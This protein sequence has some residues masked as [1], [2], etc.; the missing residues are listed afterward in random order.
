M[1]IYNRIFALVK[2]KGITKKKFLDDLSIAQ[3]AIIK[4]KNGS[5]PST[6]VL[7]KI[8]DYL[9][10]SVDYLLC[11]TNFREIPENRKS[12]SLLKLELIHKIESSDYNDERIRILLNLV[13]DVED[14]G[15]EKE[16]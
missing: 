7:I 5:L 2:E 10:V 14:F 8:A 12:A 13:N 9:N 15:E 16:F 3:S 4:W 6:P 11:R 1:D